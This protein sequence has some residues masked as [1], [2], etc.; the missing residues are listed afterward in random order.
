VQINSL[1]DYTNFVK[2]SINKLEKLQNLPKIDLVLFIKDI[3]YYFDI[4]SIKTLAMK[5][6]KFEE[7]DERLQNSLFEEIY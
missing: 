3:I 5:S 7:Y 6:E 2:E 1:T 4:G